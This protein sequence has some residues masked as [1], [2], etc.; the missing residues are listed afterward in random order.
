MAADKYANQETSYVKPASTP[1]TEQVQSPRDGIHA[2]KDQNIQSPRDPA[3]GQ[4]TSRQV[5][6]TGST[7]SPLI[8]EIGFPAAVNSAAGGP[9]AAK[10]EGPEIDANR[11]VSQAGTASGTYRE[12]GVNDTT[13]QR[14][15]GIQSPRDPASGQ[16]TGVTAQY[17]PKELGVD[18]IHSP[19]DPASGQATARTAAP[20]SQDPQ[21]K[22]T[23]E[24][25]LISSA[26]APVAGATGPQPVNG[27]AGG[28]AG[29]SERSVNPDQP[30]NFSLSSSTPGSTSVART[31]TVNANE[32]SGAQ[33]G[34]GTDNANRKRMHPRNR[35]RGKR[36]HK[37]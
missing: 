24:D 31:E 32:V 36:M 20:V 35:A 33:D 37:P 5:Q 2:E 18:T 3:S 26:K 29:A 9:A 17:N 6:P 28:A 30:K 8:T 1:P 16:A 15:A 21:F 12:G 13:Y 7:P 11:S 25:V 22:V 34:S 10:W 27:T 4:A 14:S 23:F 19:R